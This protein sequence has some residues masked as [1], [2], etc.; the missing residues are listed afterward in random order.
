MAGT[1]YTVVFWITFMS[2]MM[3]DAAGLVQYPLS[4]FQPTSK[5]RTLGSPIP[6]TLICCRFPLLGA[7][8]GHSHEDAQ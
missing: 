2:L 8:T 7:R 3:Q 4:R 1:T 6:G 5:R